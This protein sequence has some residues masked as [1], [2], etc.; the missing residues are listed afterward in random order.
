MMWVVIF[1]A[2]LYEY[3]YNF[4]FNTE[5]HE[6]ECLL[7]A[8]S[9]KANTK[10][11]LHVTNIIKA[12]QDSWNDKTKFLSEPNSSCM[13]ACVIDTYSNNLA[14]IFVHTN[15][16]HFSEFNWADRKSNGNYLA[17]WSQCLGNLPLSSLIFSKNCIRGIVFSRGQL[18]DVGMIRILGESSSSKL[19]VPQCWIW[20]DDN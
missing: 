14:L 5:S 17:N 6:N 7:L 13:N 15:T 1:Q 10:S 3:L 8:N 2:C 4:L 16:T 18:Q 9:Y 19:D 12:N 20:E 11:F